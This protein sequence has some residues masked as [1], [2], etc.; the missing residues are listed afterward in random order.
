MKQLYKYLFLGSF[1]G[2][3]YYTIELIYRGFSHWSMFILAFICFIIMGGLN[4]WFKWETPLW[5]QSIISG[6]ICTTLEFVT[7]CIVNLWLGLNVWHY[8][9]FD[10]L[11]QVSLP[12]FFIWCGLSLIGI[13]LDD[14]IRYFIFGEE[15]PMYHLK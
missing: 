14:Y 6:T 12:F 2:I 5:K 8:D 9:K 1:G 13:I 10:I 3:L 11:G 15:K 4:E 7:G